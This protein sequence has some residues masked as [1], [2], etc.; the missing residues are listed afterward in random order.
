VATIPKL[1]AVV[2]LVHF[3]GADAMPFFQP[4]AEVIMRLCL[5]FPANCGGHNAVMPFLFNQLQVCHSEF[6]GGVGVIC[7]RY[8]N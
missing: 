4:T 8:Q 7:S 3:A 6:F 5:F 1:G 2:V